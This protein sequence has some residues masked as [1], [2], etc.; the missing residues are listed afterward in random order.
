MQ[1]FVIAIRSSHMKEFLKNCNFLEKYL[2]KSTFFSRVL[3]WRPAILL[4]IKYLTVTFQVYTVYTVLCIY[5]IKFIL[6]YFIWYGNISIY[7]QMYTNIGRI[8]L[9]KSYTESTIPTPSVRGVQTLVC[10]FRDY[11]TRISGPR[12]WRTALLLAYALAQGSV[13]SN[14]PNKSR[15]TN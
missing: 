5:I 3:S 4:T 1:Y 13:C 7:M 9:T 8:P 14:C 11:C 12:F 6:L 10:W 15:I 2:W